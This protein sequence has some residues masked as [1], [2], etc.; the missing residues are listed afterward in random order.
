MTAIWYR[1]VYGLYTYIYI[2][3]GVWRLEICFCFGFCFFVLHKIPF[4]YEPYDILYA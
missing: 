4:V 1:Y 2:Y 3:R